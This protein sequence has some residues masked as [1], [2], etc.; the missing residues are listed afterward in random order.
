MFQFKRAQSMTWIGFISQVLSEVDD[1][2]DDFVI[3]IYSNIV[4]GVITY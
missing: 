3:I 2:V 4:F 1:E